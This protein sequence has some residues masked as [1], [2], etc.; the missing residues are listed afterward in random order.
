MKTLLFLI[1]NF[2]PMKD[3]INQ[4]SISKKI[5]F[6][7][8]FL[9]RDVE[10]RIVSAESKI[11]K[12]I[13]MNDGQDCEALDL[14]KTLN[15][16]K[17]KGILIVAI[18]CNENR[19]R[20]Y[21]TAIMAD[22]KKR[23]DLAKNHADFV[24][25]ELLPKILSEYDLK[26]EPKNQYF[27]GFSLGGLSAL[28]VVINHPQYFSKAGVFS[29]SFWWRKKAYEDGYDDQNDRIMHV[30]I[31]NMKPNLEQSYWLQCGTNDEK[32][33]RN[34]NGII[35]SIDDT[36]DL[37]VELCQKGFVLNQQVF[38]QET[39]NGE[40]NPQTWGFEMPNFLKWVLQD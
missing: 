35:D 18:H 25:N 28:D 24:V 22:Y 26:N 3:S 10:Y 11:E 13:F 1:F 31:R 6:P 12:V 9:N 27:M 7:S 39:I 40:H 14:V 4:Y 8:K 20:E 37:I 23:G 32:S 17:P 5:I 34:G 21:G 29:G 30:Q 19:M 38:Y 33:D 36:Q 16:L 15:I 2:L